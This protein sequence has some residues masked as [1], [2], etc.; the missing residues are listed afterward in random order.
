MSL[1]AYDLSGESDE[2]NTEETLYAKR[3]KIENVSD[4]KSEYFL[5]LVDNNFV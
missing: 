2:D 4:N 5:L 1:V 3:K